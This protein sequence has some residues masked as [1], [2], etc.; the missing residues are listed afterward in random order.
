[1]I[2]VDANV[3]FKWLV[4]EPYSRQARR[5]R[6]EALDAGQMIAAPPLILY[7]ITNIL[8]QRIRR[9]TLS[10]ED[11][12]Q[13]LLNFLQIPLDLVAPGGIHQRA[14]ALADLFR[15]PA[16]YDAHYIA[17]A[18]MLD[19]DFWTADERLIN[20]LRGGVPFVKWIG[21]FDTESRG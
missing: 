1:V 8:R 19:C 7:E 21:D 4:E 20:S 18:E 6:A 12:D 10:L 5:L 14:L 2:I 16:A 3:A 11:A 15:L 9:G 17:L 13:L